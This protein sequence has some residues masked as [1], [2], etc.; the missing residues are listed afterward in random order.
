MSNNNLE[1]QKIIHLIEIYRNHNSSSDISEL[2][3]RAT[4]I[5]SNIATTCTRDDEIA[6]IRKIE[7]CQA[8]VRDWDRIAVVGK[9][10]DELFTMPCKVHVDSARV[11]TELNALLTALAHQ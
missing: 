10:Y 2:K 9:G 8:V 7:R 11:L 1:L 6:I 5:L 4:E 3:Q